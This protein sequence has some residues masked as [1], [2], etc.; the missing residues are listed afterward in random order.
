MSTPT[1]QQVSDFQ[2]DLDTLRGELTRVIVGQTDAVEAALTAVVVGGHLLIEGPP[3]LG[4]TTLVETLAEA[5]QLTSQRVPF[6]PDLTPADLLGTYVVMESAA[7]RRTFEFQK[8]PIFSHLVLADHI[9][10]G[11][12]KTQSALLEAMEGEE[13]SVATEDFSLPQPF[14]VLATQNPLEMEGTYP[15][16]EPQLDRFLL[17]VRVAPPSE[18]ELE[19]ILERTT[20]EPPPPTRA[21][22]DGA[23]ILEM[24]AVAAGVPISSE[25][26]RAAV[27]CVAATHPGHDRA[28]EAVRRFVRYGASPRGAQALVRCAKAAAAAAGREAVERADLLAV[29][30]EA[31]RHRLILNY[32]GQAEGV[33]PD[34]LIT[35][36]AED[37]LG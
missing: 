22:L 19:E 24:R 18:E 21:V 30:H 16:P 15:L 35:A 20:D 7:G 17:K 4:K 8:G 12:P 5:L 36:I 2:R 33:D 3:G 11:L 26:R 13:I 9:N 10:R 23:R 25:L 34:T 31:I 37:V 6:T 27:T 32:E 1:Q 28:P 29:C 14:F